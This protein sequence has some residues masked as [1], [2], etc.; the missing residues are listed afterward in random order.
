MT[1]EAL[2]AEADALHRS[3]FAGPAPPEVTR[4]FVAANRLCFGDADPD[5]VVATIVAR[6]LDAEGIE[7]ALRRRVPGSPLSRKIQILFYLL[8]VRQEYSRQFLGER[9]HRLAAGAALL[10]AL[11]K[12]I[13]KFVKGEYLVRRYRLV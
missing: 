5:P 6:R 11:G 8:E 4:R 10:S 3:F 1:D 13:W 12:T 7:F 9:E 2:A